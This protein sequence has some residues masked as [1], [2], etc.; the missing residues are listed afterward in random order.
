M[1]LR[2]PRSTLF[3]YT[4]LFRSRCALRLGVRSHIDSRRYQMRTREYLVPSRI[5]ARGAVSAG[6]LGGRG[7]LAGGGLISLPL[8]A[9][10]GG[11]GGVQLAYQPVAFGFQGSAVLGPIG[12]Q[13]RSADVEAI[14]GAHR[15]SSIQ[16]AVQIERA[17]C[18][19]RV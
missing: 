2:P 3:P 1:S 16:R 13:L 4:T 19:E 15:V 10:G 14:I 7:E 11:P 12:V 6:T 17:S 18:R 9:L 5:M 8:G